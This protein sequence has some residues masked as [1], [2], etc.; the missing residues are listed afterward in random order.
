MCICASYS[1]T[2]VL[3]T[4]FY[5]QLSINFGVHHPATEKSNCNAT[6]KDNRE[7]PTSGAMTENVLVCSYLWRKEK[8]EFLFVQ[9]W[10][11]R[12]WGQRLGWGTWCFVPMKNT[13]LY[14]GQS[15]SRQWER[16]VTID[17]F[18]SK[19]SC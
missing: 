12:C 4:K 1:Q 10:W 17:S 18:Y 11:W 3:Q 7:M 19:I 5:K 2:K 14:S 16:T 9:T 15:F 8:G 13:I 6:C